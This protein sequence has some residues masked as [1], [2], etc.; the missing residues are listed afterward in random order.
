M[1]TKL[2]IVD[3]HVLHTCRRHSAGRILV[4]NEWPRTDFLWLRLLW[5]MASKTRN[6]SA[7][8]A[9]HDNMRSH[10]LYRRHM[11]L[12]LHPGLAYES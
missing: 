6:T 2:T 4:P 9:V 8:G 5:H 11:L 10:N 1:L 12:I 7:V 3:K